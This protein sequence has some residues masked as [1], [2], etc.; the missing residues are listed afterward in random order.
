MQTDAFHAAY[1]TDADR[2]ALVAQLEAA[3]SLDALP[4]DLQN[5]LQEW[6]AGVP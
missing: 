4:R 1:P 2:A 5:R 6:A 3:G